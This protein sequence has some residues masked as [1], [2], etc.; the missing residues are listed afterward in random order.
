MIE[1]AFPKEFSN[2]LDAAASQD[3]HWRLYA[4]WL[5]DSYVNNFSSALDNRVFVALSCLDPLPKQIIVSNYT[6]S[7]QAFAAFMG[8]GTFFQLYDGL[9]CSDGGATSGP[10]MTP[11]FT[12]GMRDQLIVDLMLTGFPVSMVSIFNVSSY[13]SLVKRGQDEAS[14]FFTSG[15]VEREPKVIT[16]CPKSAHTK[17]GEC[18]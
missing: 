7:D 9:A 6:S 14:Q 12:D 17:S 13:A 15:T 10:R 3:H 11:L 8:T 16:H 18:K 2:E 4:R 5:V 1:E